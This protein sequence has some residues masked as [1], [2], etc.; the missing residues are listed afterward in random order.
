MFEQAH[1]TE[2]EVGDEPSFRHVALYADLKEVVRRL[3]L[4]FLVPKEPIS[5]DRA[6]LLNL[7]FWDPGT[8]DVLVDAVIDA[9]VVAH[10]AWHALADKN[11]APS[12]AAHVLG[13]AIASAFDMYLVGRLLGHS[14]DSSFLGSQVPRMAEVAEAA[15]MSSESFETLLED[16]ARSPEAAFEEVRQLLFDAGTALLRERTPVGAASALAALDGRKF[17]PLL[18]HFELVTWVLRGR[19]DASK[20]A[21]SAGQD[22][23]ELDAKLRA[24]PD[25]IAFLEEHWVRH[26]AVEP[27][28][29]AGRGGT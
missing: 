12:A 11:L 19:L 27:S 9:D 26:M 24:A 20:E 5:F 6:L 8:S 25:A 3:E 22:A 23:R 21:E 2:L 10:V 15:G 16:V 28:D 4:R 13:E 29:A 14:P 17:A 1:I 7:A 18:H